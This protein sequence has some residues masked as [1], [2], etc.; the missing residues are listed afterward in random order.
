MIEEIEVGF[1]RSS[2]V[3]SGGVDEAR[4]REAVDIA[5]DTFEQAIAEHGLLAGSVRGEVEMLV[6]TAI[7]RGMEI[8]R[9][10]SGTDR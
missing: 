8:E 5:V 6:A 10:I 9:E 2:V 4:M 3:I 1:G 7:V